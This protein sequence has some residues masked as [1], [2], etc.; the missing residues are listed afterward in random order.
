VL[1]KDQKNRNV[2]AHYSPGGQRIDTHISYS[3]DE[4]PSGVRDRANKKYHSNYS[5]NRIERPN[6]QPLYQIRSDN[7]N[8]TYMDKKNK[9]RKYKDNH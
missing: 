5:S 6:S 9:N 8:T 7:G 2:A 1:I 3:Q 4:L